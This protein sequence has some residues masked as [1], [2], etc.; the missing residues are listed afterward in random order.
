[1]ND[2]ISIGA[3]ARLA[4]LQVVASELGTSPRVTH[5]IL[6]A[7]GVP[8][9]C[10]SSLVEGAPD[11]LFI[12]VI[13]L[14]AALLRCL[15]PDLKSRRDVME[16]MEWAGTLSEG[17]KRKAVLESIGGNSR[18]WKRARKQYLKHSLSSL[19]PDL[20]ETDKD[21]R[22]KRPSASASTLANGAGS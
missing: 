3:G 21:F 17:A 12:Q 14:E 7:L 15:V 11:T 6:E 18:L 16:Y 10:F 1:M 5:N 8:I 2:I 13:E 20:R 22:T 4:S 9:L 19:R